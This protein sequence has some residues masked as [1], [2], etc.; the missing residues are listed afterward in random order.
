MEATI[1]LFSQ[2]TGCGQ[3]EAVRFLSARGFDVE[4]AVV[5]WATHFDWFAESQ[6]FWRDHPPFPVALLNENLFA[7]TPQIAKDKDG[8]PVLIANLVHWKHYWRLDNLDALREVQW[9][10]AWI[11]N[12]VLDLLP[13]VESTG[14]TLIA[15][16]T[17]LDHIDDVELIPVT[18][19]HVILVE[20][21]VNVL[22]VRIH[23]FIS[24]NGEQRSW[25]DRFS[26]RVSA[27]PGFF[28]RSLG[29]ETID[30]DPSTLL[31]HVDEMNLPLSLGGKLDYNH[32]EWFKEQDFSNLD[33][34]IPSLPPTMQHPS[35]TVAKS[36]AE[37]E[38]EPSV[39]D[40]F[41]SGAVSAAD[42]SIKRIK[43]VAVNLQHQTQQQPQ[44]S[45]P[46][47]TSPEATSAYLAILQ[48]F[49][50]RHVN[51]FTAL[52]RPMNE[53]ES[54]DAFT[55]ALGVAKEKF[56][57]ELNG[58]DLLNAIETDLKTTESEASKSF[59]EKLLN[60]LMTQVMDAKK[61]WE[62]LISSRTLTT[63]DELN[64][65]CT[66]LLAEMKPENAPKGVWETVVGAMDEYVRKPLLPVIQ[67]EAAKD[68]VKGKEKA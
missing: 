43:T 45:I 4:K 66:D 21:I 50:S 56:G 5:L 60:S 52:G 36:I 27:V 47:N 35:V 44:T 57:T 58:L 12:R 28:G 25:W 62:F 46:P 29:L 19:M 40:G 13:D 37:Y 20:F 68:R 15:D 67:D 10:T 7:F 1:A 16:A 8:R 54:R 31:N 39:F 42:L 24:F 53:Q 38:Q 55:A 64:A 41:V 34:T 49:R 18:Q 2:R 63:E 26:K 17:H 48:D 33:Y 14:L 32:A 59:S 51:H 65:Q 3:K 6:R 30:C 23:K 61:R 11:I 9:I 22:P